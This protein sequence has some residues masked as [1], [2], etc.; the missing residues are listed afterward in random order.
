MCDCNTITYVFPRMRRIY[1]VSISTLAIANSHTITK[2]TQLSNSMCQMV[3]APKHSDAK[4]LNV[5]CIQCWIGFMASLAS[6]L[7]QRLDGSL[8]GSMNPLQR[9][10]TITC[11]VSK[12]NSI[13]FAFR[14]QESTID[15]CCEV[16]LRS[17]RVTQQCLCI[18]LLNHVLAQ[19]SVERLL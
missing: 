13:W 14:W 15:G 7:D 11:L 16:S 17:E 18:V 2:A 5:T 6:C 1:R 10:S 19:Y 9:I 3:F 4:G 12:C 8:R